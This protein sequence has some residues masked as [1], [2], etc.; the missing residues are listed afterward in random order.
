MDTNTTTNT[1]ELDTVSTQE[2]YFGA[3][4][5]ERH[6][7]PD[8]ISFVLLKELDEGDRRAY[9]NKTNKDIRVERQTGDAHLRIASGDERYYLLEMAIVGWNL[10]RKNGKT[11]V[12]EPLPFN[13][14]NR[15]DFLTKSRPGL[16]DGVEKK[17]RDMNLWLLPSELTEEN[18]KE[19]IAELEEQLEKVRE[20][21]AKN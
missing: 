20:R 3:D 19:Q 15:K 12:I 7:L 16:L 10:V 4:L 11:G 14:K 18:I 21:D 17:I 2:D 5:T 1:V 9:L 8:G 6:T 13:E